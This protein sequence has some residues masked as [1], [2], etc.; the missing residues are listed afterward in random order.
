MS[1]VVEL[2]LSVV[3]LKDQLDLVALDILCL[4]FRG[5]PLLIWI[6]LPSPCAD[7]VEMCHLGR[8]MERCSPE[9]TF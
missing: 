8:E 2:Y 1:A 6:G 7:I 9:L 5:N 3:E 4:D